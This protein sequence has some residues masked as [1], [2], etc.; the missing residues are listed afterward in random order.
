[1]NLGNLIAGMLIFMLIFISMA[2][3]NCLCS[4]ESDTKVV[5]ISR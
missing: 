3:T 5:L 1:M 2:V 4:G